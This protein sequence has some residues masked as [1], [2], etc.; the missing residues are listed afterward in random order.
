MPAKIDIN[1]L[2]PFI[3][4]DIL[5]IITAEINKPPELLVTTPEA[6]CDRRSNARS[7]LSSHSSV[8]ALNER[9]ERSMN[10][11]EEKAIELANRGR[12]VK[13]PNGWLV[14]S[15]NSSEK[16]YVTI[17]PL[18]CTCPDFELRQEPCK[19]ILA[20]QIVLSR[21]ASGSPAEQNPETLPI[22]WPRKTYRQ[23]WPNYDAAQQNEKREFQCLLS[24]LCSTI[25]QPE[26]K[27]GIKGGRPTARLSD[28]IFASVFKVYCGLS[29][30]RFATDLHE[31]QERGFISQ[32]VHHSTVARYLEDSQTTP[33]LISLIEAS[34]LPFKAI[35]TEFAVDSSGFSSSRFDRWYEEKW[36][37][38]M[39]K[40]SWAKVHA[41]V[42]TT[43]HIVVGVIIDGKDSPDSPQFSP[44]V[45]T[46]AK[47][48][49]IDQ[50]TVDKAYASRENFNAVD[51]VGGT[52][53]AAFKSSAT[54]AA[55]GV[56]GRMYHLFCLNK[57]E[58]LHH[59]HRRSNIESLFSAVKRLF[60]DAV[61]SKSDTAMRNE[62]LAKLLAYNIT[63]LVHAIYE[64]N[65][66]PRLIGER[67]EE[68]AILPM[69]WPG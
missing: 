57:E 46:A 2:L 33:L 4:D 6:R 56:Y 13:R 8:P 54:G 36:G 65:L 55:G 53:Y 20:V 38:M 29:G 50:V 67:D 15:L 10:I 1:P 42:G 7:T 63:L 31:A 41:I 14:Y 60:G 58:Y 17:L 19:H 52:L 23:D 35:E 59:Y 22:R 28:V 62:S 40:Q 51:A 5:Y 39:S 48:F 27:G 26:P 25:P 34:A 47:N 69:R 11:R 24:D 21:E 37:R 68:P 61:R 44:L 45:K 12:V 32:T 18:S 30:R 9:G 16:Y 66:E 43:T 64:L 49:T 3:C